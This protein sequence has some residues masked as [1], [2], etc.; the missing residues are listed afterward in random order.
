ML[1]NAFCWLSGD[2]NETQPL[3]TAFECNMSTNF[4]L[5]VG[6]DQISLTDGCHT[7]GDEMLCDANPVY[8]ETPDLELAADYCQDI[9]NEDDACTGY[10]FQKHQN[11]HEIC[12]FYSEVID[13]SDGTWHGHQEGSRVCK[14]N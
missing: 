2:C 1:D 3:D 13:L 5:G 12:G 14:K 10:F 9:C 8:H 7:A 11:G 6:Y 4:I